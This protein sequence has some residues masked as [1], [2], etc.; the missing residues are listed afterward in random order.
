MALEKEIP[1]RPADVTGILAAGTLAILGF[2]VLPARRRQAMK[3]LSDK[4]LDLRQRLMGSLTDQFDREVNRSIH[5]IEEAMA[6]YTRFVRAERDRLDEMRTDLE[7]SQQAISVPKT[8]IE[9]L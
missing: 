6:P 8:Q 9:E 1:I 5:R 7:R 2:L 4:M 3:E